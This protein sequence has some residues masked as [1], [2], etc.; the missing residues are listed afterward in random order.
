[1]RDGRENAGKAWFSTRTVLCLGKISTQ[2]KLQCLDPFLTNRFCKKRLGEKKTS[3]VCEYLSLCVHVCEAMAAFQTSLYVLFDV[4]E[5]PKILSC[6]T[7]TLI[8]R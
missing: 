3:C 8:P 7:G 6:V 4:S 2:S 1:M 5:N